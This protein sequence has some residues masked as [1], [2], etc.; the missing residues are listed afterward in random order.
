MSQICSKCGKENKSD[1]KFCMSCGSPLAGQSSGLSNI[2]EVASSFTEK[3]KI[4]KRLLAK[5]KGLKTWKKVVICIVAGM[6]LLFRLTPD[7]GSPSTTAAS[8]DTEQTETTTKSDT[9]QTETTTKSDT[10]Q[11]E[12]AGESDTS[13]Q[14]ASDDSGTTTSSSTSSDTAAT[15]TKSNDATVKSLKKIM[16]K[17][18]GYGSDK[19]SVTVTLDASGNAY[20]SYTATNVTKEE[21]LIDDCVSNYINFSRKAY[22]YDNVTLTTFDIKTAMVDSYGNVDD[23]L[24]FSMQ[25]TKDNFEKYKWDNLFDGILQSVE[26]NCSVLYIH[27]SILKEIDTSKIYYE[28]K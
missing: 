24:I 4:S 28:G 2:D 18:N 5:W 14:A 20:V 8:S 1:S 15:A 27:P 7:S 3:P 22:K 13:M 9:D 16:E 21:Y 12:T 6:M 17:I 19:E 10:D 11:T 25:M 23:V 26:P